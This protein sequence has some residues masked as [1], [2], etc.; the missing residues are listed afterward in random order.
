MTSTTPDPANKAVQRAQV[1][2]VTT[3]D[4][5]SGTVLI[6]QGIERFETSIGV[7]P[8]AWTAPRPVV[9]MTYGEGKTRQMAAPE[10]EALGRALMLSA[11]ASVH[12]A[13][14]NTP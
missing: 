9:T 10:A 11:A 5:E 8:G 13:E 14:V 3:V 12:A 2:P 1:G 4:T 6:E 7:E